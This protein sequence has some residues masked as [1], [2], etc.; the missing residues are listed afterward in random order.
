MSLCIAVDKEINGQG[1]HQEQ[2]DKVEEGLTS[3]ID[4]ERHE[5]GE[6]P[7]KLDPAHDKVSMLCCAELQNSAC[8]CPT[9]P[10]DQQTFYRMFWHKLFVL[11]STLPCRA[12]HALSSL[13]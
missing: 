3:E 6:A 11:L 12:T 13:A 1:D 9:F 5:G 10:H 7:S 8:C 4:A 2:Q